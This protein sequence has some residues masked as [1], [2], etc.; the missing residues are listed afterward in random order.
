M[1]TIKFRGRTFG[2]KWVFGSLR[3]DLG[4]TMIGNRRTAYGNNSYYG[5]VT[6]KED[7][8]WDSNIVDPDTVGQFTGVYDKNGREI[9]EGDILKWKSASYDE[10][11]P[12]L[13]VLPVTFVCGCFCVNADSSMPLTDV[14]SM[15]EE[16]GSI[17]IAGNVY[18]S[19]GNIEET[20]ETSVKMK[21]KNYIKDPS[22]MTDEDRDD[23][24]SALCSYLPYKTNCR[25]QGIDR[26][27]LKIDV[28]DNDP[29]VMGWKIGQ[30]RPYLRPISSMT[31][32]EKKEISKLHI[33]ISIGTN[34][35]KLCDLRGFDWLN[36]HHFDYRGLIKKGLAIEA[37]EEMYKTK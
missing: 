31:S 34:E 24:L 20:A 1:R 16:F 29:E 3:D 30:C 17:E 11:E 22:E 36:S 5:G 8:Y 13:W 14:I 23:L 35:L 18:E 28:C 21:K 26:P 32:S 4:R 2:G 6:V 9:Y 33:S 12:I 19:S 37:P 25:I 10:E 15:S 27:L 7:S